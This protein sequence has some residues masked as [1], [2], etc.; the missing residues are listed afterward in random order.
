MPINAEF[1]FVCRI[2]PIAFNGSYQF[3]LIFFGRRVGSFQTSGTWLLEII[4]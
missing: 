1:L 2:K 3:P 4:S